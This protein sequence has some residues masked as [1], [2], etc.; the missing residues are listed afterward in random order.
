MSDK[1]TTDRSSKYKRSA[2]TFY[3]LVFNKYS[4]GEAIEK[5]AGKKYM[6]QNPYISYVKDAFI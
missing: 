3:D 2:V 4:P 5:Y 6:Q 1:I